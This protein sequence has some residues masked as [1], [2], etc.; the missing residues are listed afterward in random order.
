MHNIG[1]NKH[2][3]TAHRPRDDWI[4]HWEQQKEC[5]TIEKVYFTKR[6]VCHVTKQMNDNPNL[7]NTGSVYSVRIMKRMAYT[8][9]NKVSGQWWRPFIQS[10]HPLQWETMSFDQKKF[11]FR[12]CLFRKFTL[13]HQGLRMLPQK[14]LFPLLCRTSEES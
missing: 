12:K 9:P 3:F 6:A 13:D 11:H 2:C 14:D 7:H 5:G 4:N 10:L 1:G 8:S